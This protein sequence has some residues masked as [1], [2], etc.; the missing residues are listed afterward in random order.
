MCDKQRLR[1]AWSLEYSMSV[2]LLTEHHLESL[3]LKGD[4]TGSSVS[5]H[6]KLPQ[7]L[8]SHATAHIEIIYDQNGAVEYEAC[9]CS[10]CLIIFL[11][12]QEKI[13]FQ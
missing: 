12:C 11:P 13:Y 9:I 1:P 4:C 3:S 5:T 10:A 2:K 6:V 8:K 7:F